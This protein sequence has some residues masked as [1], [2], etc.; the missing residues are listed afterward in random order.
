MPPTLAIRAR[1]AAIAAE[2]LAGVERIDL[3]AE[4]LAFLLAALDAMEARLV[5]VCERLGAAVDPARLRR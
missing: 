3:D 4:A 2:A 1:L 5:D